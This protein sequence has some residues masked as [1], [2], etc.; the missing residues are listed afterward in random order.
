MA[1]APVR[2]L[3]AH[4]TFS[5]GGKEARAVRLMNAFG[6]AARH[7]IWSAM[8]DRLSAREA[9]AAG[10][11]AEMAEDAPLLAG[12]PTP[13]RLRRLARYMQGFDLVLSYNWGAFDAVMT[14]RLFVGM[15]LPPMIHHEDGF[16]EDE[17]KSL[18]PTRNLY[19]RV[20][21]PAVE[22]L[23]VPSSRLADIA[24]TC[25]GQPAEHLHRI[26]NGIEVERYA[27]PPAPDAIAGFERRAGEL[28][29]GTVAGMRAV[30]DLPR[31]VRVFAQAR[32]PNAR[33]VIAGEGP[34][35]ERIVAE[36][37]AQGVMDRLV[38]PG[39]LAEPSRWIGL[40]DIFALSSRS[41]QFPISLIEAM[42]AGVPVVSTAVGD[43]PD[44]LSR[45]N[46]FAVAES[47]EAL[48][49]LLARL[50]QDEALRRELGEANRQKARAR[51]D[52]Q[53]MIARYAGLY[54]AAIGRPDAFAGA[55]VPRAQ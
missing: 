54:G 36:A 17:A 10:V 37:T 3:H 40:F 43:V 21:L 26:P 50:A 19:R 30:K 4:S 32:L 1:E 41:E 22:A 31:L 47:D 12:K 51:F 48:S 35:R 7:T 38:M 16:N 15:G 52:E 55:A 42:A 33:L 49:G 44:M 34:E 11:V 53:M 5:L 24:A 2:I 8:P 18:K 29:V 46:R 6:D 9:I 14:R 20:G 45:A 25:W 27:Q 13:G 28:V 39:F 23:I